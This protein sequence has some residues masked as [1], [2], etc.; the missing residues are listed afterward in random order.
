MEGD[1]HWTLSLRAQSEI[2]RGLNSRRVDFHIARFQFQLQCKKNKS[3]QLVKYMWHPCF[4]R[5]ALLEY[6]FHI[7]LLILVTWEIGVHVFHSAIV[8]YVNR[9]NYICPTIHESHGGGC[10]DHAFVFR[11]VKQWAV[12]GTLVNTRMP[13]VW[14]VW[15]WTVYI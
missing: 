14:T 12:K 3:K 7:T 4:R 9:V 10:A 13:P 8:I 15:K 11:C 1:Q 5:S 2:A 6:W